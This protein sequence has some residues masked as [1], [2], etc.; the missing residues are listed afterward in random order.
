MTRV[1]ALFNQSG[2]VGKTTITMNLG[3]QL[4]SRGHRV[5]LID[6]DPQASLTTFMGLDVGKQDK[7]IYDALISEEELI[8]IY[9]NI[10]Q[11]DL[12]PATILLANAEQELVLAEQRELRLK[13]PLSDIQAQYDFILLDCPPSLG[14]LSQIS[15]VAA[16]HVLVPIQTQFKA[17]MGTDSLLQTVKKVQ[18]RLN[19]TLTFAGFCP[20]MYSPSNALD[21]R[22]LEAI[23]D[24]L[25]PLGRIFTPISR[26]TALAEASEYGK[27]LAL[28]PK[29]NVSVLAVFDEIAIAMEQI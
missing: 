23:T 16:T 21:Q 28:S 1:I 3:Y 20:T 8:P 27:P 15:L 19:K 4:A 17:L 7:T 22:T 13:E 29:K 26:A 10:H 5:L 6:M 18:R 14:I 12:S 25:A 2:G 11:M 9:P 24:Q